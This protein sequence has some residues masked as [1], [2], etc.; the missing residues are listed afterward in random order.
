MTNRH[1]RKRVKVEHVV[2]VNGTPV[3]NPELEYEIQEVLD[4]GKRM[5]RAREWIRV[6]LTEFRRVRAERD[7]GQ[8]TLKYLGSIALT[9]VGHIEDFYRVR[10]A[11]K[12]KL[13]TER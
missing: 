6:L 5:T 4:S 2:V 13:D 11:A 10:E 3:W 8:Q 9:K 7:D 1:R 12:R